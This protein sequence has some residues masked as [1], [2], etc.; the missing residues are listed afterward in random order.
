METPHPIAEGDAISGV[1]HLITQEGV[2]AY[3]E[4]SGD[5]N[6]IHLDPEFASQ[7]HFGRRIAHGMMIAAT[8]SELMAGA[9]GPDWARSGWMKLRFRTPVYPGD[10]VETRGTVKKVEDLDGDGRR[11]TCTVEAVR[12]SGDHEEIA[13]IA[14]TSVVMT[15]RPGQDIDH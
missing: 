11:I 14:Q 1:S 8:I 13:I 5:F 6:P 3:A 4:A 15:D 9:F 12:E 10:R 7:S 2:G